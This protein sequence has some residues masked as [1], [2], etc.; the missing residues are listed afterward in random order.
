MTYFSDLSP[1]VYLRRVREPHSVN[2]GW[3]ERDYPY[4]QQAPSDTTLDSLWRFCAVAV[5]QTR[6]LHVCSLCETGHSYFIAQRN[7]KRIH[8]GSAEIAVISNTGVVYSAPNLIYHYARTHHYRPS[9]DFLQ[10]LQEAPKP[11]GKEYFELLRAA[12]LEWSDV[13][14]PVDEPKLIQFD[15]SH[16]ELRRIEKPASI[17]LDAD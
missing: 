7:G 5:R 12:G 6:G 14:S 2:I 13:L 15:S 3:L 8:L 16:G 1:Y 9:D 11:P 10:A 17:F 4:V